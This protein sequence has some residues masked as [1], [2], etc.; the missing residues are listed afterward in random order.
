MEKFTIQVEFLYEL[1]FDYNS[2][3]FE[4]AYANYT[5]CIDK[6]ATKLDM[7]KTIAYQINKFGPKTLVEGVGYVWI[8]GEKKPEKDWCGVIVED[9]E[10]EPE[11]DTY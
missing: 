1:K 9:G 2:P 3:E 10:P 4:K 5:A 11:V 7:L 6:F 8:E